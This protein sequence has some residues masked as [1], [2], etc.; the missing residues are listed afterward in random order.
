[1]CENLSVSKPTQNQ[2]V[3]NCIF[4]S[5]GKLNLGED[6]ILAEKIMMKWLIWYR[7]MSSKFDNEEDWDTNQIGLS[8][9]RLVVE[10]GYNW[11][12]VEKTQ[13]KVLYLVSRKQCDVP[14]IF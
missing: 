6:Q 13:N 12:D 5:I 4:T 1:M 2:I 3:C 14:S 9:M 10:E 8:L 7:D 11:D